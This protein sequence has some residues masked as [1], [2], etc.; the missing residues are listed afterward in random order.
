M[1]KNKPIGFVAVCQC[2]E[3]V[4]AMDYKRTERKDAGKLLGQ[5]LHHGCTVEPRFKSFSEKITKCK[6]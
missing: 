4:G 5:W 3:K 1:G 2:G 6:C